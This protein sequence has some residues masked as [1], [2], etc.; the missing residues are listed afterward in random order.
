MLCQEASTQDEA[1]QL[2][3]CHLKTVSGTSQDHPQAIE[4]PDENLLVRHFDTENAS[5]AKDSKVSGRVSVL[6]KR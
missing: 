6:A 4:L 5:A 2:F 3:E 1:P